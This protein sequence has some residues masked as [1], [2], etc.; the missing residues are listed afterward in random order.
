MNVSICGKDVGEEVASGQGEVFD[1][2]SKCVVGMFD[3]RDG[4]ID[5]RRGRDVSERSD[6][7]CK[8]KINGKN[9]YFINKRG[10]NNSPNI[11]EQISFDPQAAIAIK[12]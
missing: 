5:A 6:T 10:D 1:D 3:T 7:E 9:A 2:E 8:P 4:N 11:T 12:P